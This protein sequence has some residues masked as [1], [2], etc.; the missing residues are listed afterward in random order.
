MNEIT[1]NSG[2]SSVELEKAHKM[3]SELKER[4][5]SYE[6]QQQQNFSQAF[7]PK[8]DEDVEMKL[9]VSSNT[10]N[11]DNISQS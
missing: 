6:Q 5:K 7:K 3:I 11:I 9:D 4:L 1:Q 8:G 10:N 2:E